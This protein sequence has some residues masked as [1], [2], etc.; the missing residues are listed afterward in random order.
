M[1]F[2]EQ[3]LSIEI[4][5]INGIEVNLKLTCEMIIPCH[6]LVLGRLIVLEFNDTST[7][8]AHF[9]LSP[10]ETEKSGRRDSRGKRGR[11][12]RGA[13]MKVKKLKK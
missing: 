4:A 3:K 5:D 11:E 10:R 13:G 1:F 9:V 8:V 7:L 6:Y 12:E 2:P